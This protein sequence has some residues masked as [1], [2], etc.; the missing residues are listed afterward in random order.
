[1]RGYRIDPRDR[2]DLTLARYIYNVEIYGGASRVKG[3]REYSL[4]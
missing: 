2:K 3:P 4:P 1:M